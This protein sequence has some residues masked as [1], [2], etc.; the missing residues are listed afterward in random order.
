MASTPRHHLVPQLLLRR[1]ADADGNLCMVKRDDPNGLPLRISVNNACNEAGFYR[2]ETEDVEP[3]HR[4]GHDPEVVEKM[5]SMFESRAEAAIEHILAGQL[6]WTDDDRFHLVNFV[7]L[8]FVRGWRYRRHMNEIGTLT[9]RR[10]L[11]S[12]SDRMTR[13]ARQHL[14]SEGRA[15]TQA[16]IDEFVAVILGPSGPKLVSS[17]PNAIQTGFE[18]AL[19]FLAERLF[20]RPMRLERFD[21]STPLLTSDSPVVTWSPDHPDKRVVP[22]ADAATITLPIS[23]TAALTFSQGGHDA[24]ATA[25]TVRARQINLAV[26]DTAERWIYFRPGTNPLGA[27]DIPPEKPHWVGERIASRI[28]DDGRYRE[29]WGTV[30]R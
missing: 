9:M 3:D 27:L 4:D 23:P 12:V 24:V 2:I 7:A 25:G 5:L 18:F 21:N 11:A 28:D 30:Q 8:H 26:A 1:F 29:L 17:Q 15:V 6:P 16:A 14:R 13:M 20:I 22:L 19:E 10:M